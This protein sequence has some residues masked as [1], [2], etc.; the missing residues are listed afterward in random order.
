MAYSSK[1]GKR[2]NEYASKTSHSHI[3]NDSSVISFLERCTIPK[4]NEE[5]EIHKEQL[6]NI[7]PIIQ[8]PILHIIAIDG[9]Y[10]EI[11]VRTEFPSSTIC[12]FQFGALV[13]NISDLESLEDQP[14][15]DPSDMS[16]LKEIQRFK[17]TLPVRNIN[18]KDQDTLTYSIRRTIF[19]FFNQNM[20]E[21]DTLIE[22]LR[23]FIFHE[24]EKKIDTWVLGSCPVCRVASVPLNRSQ[25]SKSYTFVCPS[26]GGQIYLTDIFRLHE[27]IDDELGASGILGYVTTTI[28]QIL[29]VHIIRLILNIKPQLLEQT[30][31]IK[32]GPLAFFGQTA[33]MHKPMRDLV[34][35]LFEFHNLYLSGLEK[36]GP[37]VEHADEIRDKLLPSSVL[38]LDNEYIYSYILPGKADPAN[39]YG[40]STNYGNKI[41]FKTKKGSMYIVSLPIAKII[42]K[43]IESDFRNLNVVLTNIEKLKCDMYDNALLPV[44]LANKLVSLANVPSSR[45]LK[46]FS[47]NI[48]NS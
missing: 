30:L 42:S 47:K 9:G 4:K 38:L 41:I 33:N 12:F 18:L 31:F 37:F 48:I 36:S 40:R 29:L 28:E 39:P 21:D 10:E 16:K 22:T 5:I 17:L 35:Y 2:P 32:D 20:G 27:A 24:Y 15:I 34:S 23:W 13:F 19:D 14:F 26:C 45:I 43:P 3:V 7:N 1:Q 6:L 8:N 44:A 46:R 11:P 25:I